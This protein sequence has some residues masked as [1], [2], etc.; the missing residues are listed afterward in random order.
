MQFVPDRYPLAS[1]FLVIYSF[2]IP[3]L[4]WRQLYMHREV[5]HL[6]GP[7]WKLGSL[8]RDYKRQFYYFG[9]LKIPC[10]KRLLLALISAWSTN[11]RLVVLVSH[12]SRHT[13]IRVPIRCRGH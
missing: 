4:F 11:N 9:P 10:C 2:G 1:T 5:L 12:T 8:Y 13:Q 7:T 6:P 3:V